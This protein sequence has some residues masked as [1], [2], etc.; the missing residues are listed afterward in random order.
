MVAMTQNQNIK[1]RG[2]GKGHSVQ[3]SH[4]VM[5]ESATPWTAALQASLSIINSQSWIKPMSIELVISYNHLILWCPL[6]LLPSVFPSVRVFSNE[7][8]LCFRWPKHQ[9]FQWIF[10]TDFI[11]RLTALNLQ[12]KEPLRVFSK[13][14]SS[15]ASFLQWQLSVQL[16][17]PYTTTGKTIALTRW[18]FVGKVMSLLCNLLLQLVI[19]FLPRAVQFSSVAQSSL[20]FCDP[21][22]CSMPGLPVHHQLPK[23]AQIQVHWVS[24]A[25]QPSHPL[26]SPSLH[27]LNL[28]QHLGLF[29]WVTSSHQVAKVLEFQLQHQ[30]FQWAPRTD[31]L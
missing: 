31:L 11:L 17:H 28:S 9:S 5:C 4:S 24:D 25:I 23:F 30:P 7:S 3:F 15:K 12:S 16:S 22:D 18:T 10:R 8:V 27:V 29:K 21:M 13:H 19:A 1:S 6:L 14:H 2:H 26:L 20:T